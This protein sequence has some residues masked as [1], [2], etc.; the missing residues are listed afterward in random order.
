[1]NFTAVSITLIICVTLIILSND[2]K[3][4]KKK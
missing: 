1:M 3:K 4:G 2:D